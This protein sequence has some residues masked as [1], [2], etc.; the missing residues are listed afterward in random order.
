MIVG[1][2]VR[3]R[4]DKFE[5]LA[6][7]LISF[8]H[9][10]ITMDPQSDLSSQQRVFTVQRVYY[11]LSVG[12]NRKDCSCRYIS[13][14]TIHHVQRSLTLWQVAALWNGRGGQKEIACVQTVP[15]WRNTPPELESLQRTV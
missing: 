10:L 1:S 3:I 5:I 2:D 9:L 15:L 4:V 13:I 8:R 6:S 12:E 11:C 14:M 7:S